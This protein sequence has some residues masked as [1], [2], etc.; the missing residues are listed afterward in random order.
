MN[1]KKKKIL[2][3][4]QCSGGV[5]RYILMLLENMNSEEYEH[6]IICSYD[7]KKEKFKNLIYMFKY[8]DMCREINFKKDITAILK[9]RKI[10]KKYSPDIVYMHSSK[11][12]AIGRLANLGIK[13]ISLYNPHGWAFNMECNNL[14]LTIYKNIEKLMSNLCT[15]IVA[16]SDF[17]KKSALEH[18]ICKEKK[19]KVIFNGIDITE[20]YKNSKGFT[21]SKSKLGIPENSYV[22]GFVGR[23][24]KQ[25]APDIFI[26][27][28]SLVKEEVENAFFIIVG[29]GEERKEIE[30]LIRE[31]N[32]ENN[33]LITGW[34]DNPMEYIKLF[35]QAFLLSRWEGFGLVL[36]EY[37]I[38]EKP[39]IATNVNAIPDIIKNNK[40]GILV[41]VDNYTEVFNSAM[42]VYKNKNFRK[43]IVKA[44]KKNAEEKFN[45]KR[46]TDDT[47]KLIQEEIEWKS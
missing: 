34:V 24:T 21:I 6:S 44:A 45:I 9:V 40:N 22:F 23:I 38:A 15:R 35:D 32:L 20:H 26:R 36:I 10:I 5:E 8:V 17:E 16:I 31:Y 7:Y 11:A 42:K 39:I 27:F 13:N 41:E 47:K 18:K 19:I 1:V 12:G 43:S 3:I 33:I 37:M 46:V 25:K 2:H 29:D 4:V 28:A 30:N 14:K